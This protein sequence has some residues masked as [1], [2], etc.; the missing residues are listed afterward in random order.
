MD[1][2]YYDFV[3]AVAWQEIRSKITGKLLKNSREGGEAEKE[4]G[5]EG[6]REGLIERHKAW[7]GHRALARP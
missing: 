2:E 3:D 5:K 4:V 6:G 7:Q 1:D